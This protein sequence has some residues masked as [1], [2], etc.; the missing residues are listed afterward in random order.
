MTGWLIFIAVI[1]LIAINS[2]VEFSQ[3]KQVQKEPEEPKNLD[4]TD[5]TGE[6]GSKEERLPDALEIL[7]EKPLSETLSKEQIEA[8]YLLEKTNRNLFI[9]GKA[10]TG[11][12]LVLQIFQRLSSKR[13]V[14]V[15][16]TGIAALNI[17]GQTIHSLFQF[18]PEFLSDEVLEEKSIKGLSS[19]VLSKLDM[20]VIDEVS[21]VRSDVMDA[22]DYRLR[23][24]K[25]NNLPFG[26][27][28]IALFG[29]PY[30][31]PPVVNDQ[32][33]ANFFSDN[34]G[35]Y[36][37]DSQSYQSAD[38]FRHELS[39]VFRQNDPEFVH[40]LNSIR[41]KERALKNHLEILNK[42]Q[43]AQ[44]PKEDILMLTTTRAQSERVNI[45]KLSLLPG[46][47]FRYIAA[48]NGKFRNDSFPAE[49]ILELKTEAQVMFLKNDSQKRWVNGTLGKV[50]TLSKNEIF[51]IVKGISYQVLPET[52]E[53]IRY[54]YDQQKKKISKEIIGTFT[55]YPL[56]LAW[57]ITIH[58]SQGQTYD[59]AFV[60]MESGAFAHGQAY[61]ALSR[62]RNL[63][64]LYLKREILESDVIVDPSVRRFMELTP[65][66]PNTYSP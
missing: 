64:G 49:S 65:T 48:I 16:P 59:S 8:L 33:M 53:S 42:R 38:V 45:K 39:T 22:I 44:S 12:S 55:Q 31:L 15:A 46:K 14:V 27:I 34:F 21:M 58:K 25:K 35:P 30:Q 19:L 28:Q 47:T 6:A 43:T 40:I 1:V 17:G 60:D 57:A 51:V 24:S 32:D 50:D 10:G 62:C 7:P 13:M 63:E 54:R 18:P 3:K 52:W 5:K 23:K 11:K 56:R 61:V 37:F 20:L 66:T 2:F 4:A 36:F 26:G 41:T 9:T 29:D